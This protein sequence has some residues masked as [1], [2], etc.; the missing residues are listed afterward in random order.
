MKKF[1]NW[2]LM[3]LLVLTLGL[4]VGCDAVDNATGTNVKAG[5]A[6]P[7]GGT[8]GSVLRAADSFLPS[9]W[10]LITHT[11]LGGLALYQ[12]I[13]LKSA[14]SA[15]DAAQTVVDSTIAGVKSFAKA[16]PASAET[17]ADHIQAA[18]TDAG[19]A[20]AATTAMMNAITPPKV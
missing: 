19:A 3:G 11:L 5:T 14:S 8:V 15:L 17:L 2:A 12:G 16:N 18:H 20:P 13:R 6:D 4:S 1:L 7:N 9:P 10:N